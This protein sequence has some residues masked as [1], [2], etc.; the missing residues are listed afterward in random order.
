[1]RC[2]DCLDTFVHYS[3]A[4]MSTIFAG[5]H[6]CGDSSI[7]LQGARSSSKR[8]LPDAETRD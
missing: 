7:G 6:F 3:S 4:T 1:V 8:N 5:T 2:L